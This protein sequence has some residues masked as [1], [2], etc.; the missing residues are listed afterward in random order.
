[1]SDSRFSRRNFLRTAGI[2]AV[3]AA[4][5]KMS[6]SVPASAPAPVAYKYPNPG[7]IVV[8]H[9]PLAVLGLNNVDA[10]VVQQMFDQA[11]MQ[12][13]GITSS[14]AAALASLFPGLT[15][16]KKIAIKPNNYNASVPARK[17]LAKALVTRLVQMLGGFPAANITFYERHTWTAPG[18]TAGYFGQ[19]VNFVTDTAFPNLGYTIHCDGKDRPYSKSLYEADYLINMPVAKSC[20]CGANFP[21]T[22]AFK[23]H[24]GTVNPSGTLGIHVNKTAVLDIMADAVMTTKQRIV[25]TDC[26]F[27]MYSG[28]PSGSPQSTPQTIMLAQ[29]P[30]TSD[31]QALKLINDLRIANNLSAVTVPYIAEAAAVPY[32]IGIADPALMNVIT[33]NMPV[34]LQSFSAVLDGE[35]VLLR[36]T[37]ASETN[38]SGFEIQ[39]S[40]D[41]E[42]WENVGFVRGRGT[43]RAASEYSY[44][45]VLPWTLRAAPLQYR[46]RQIDFDG[47]S[48]YS[49]VV[50]VRP[51]AERESWSMDRNYPNPVRSQTDILVHAAE[52]MH[53][54][55]E[56]VDVTGRVV[57]VLHDA[58]M[59]A[60][61]R[62]LRWDAFGCAPGVYVCRAVAEGRVKEVGM[63]VRR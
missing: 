9:H 63:V 28:G 37:T 38:N 35:N 52:R 23:N 39:R 56:V 22:L 40:R 33:V 59:E 32:E 53:L 57:A 16:S 61:T 44:A 62:R 15:T 29:D 5:P 24:M 25:L 45:D 8:V 27:A 6:G 60:G 42:A 58:H 20:A 12:F 46:L 31:Y 34:E 36:W 13:T 1:M 11:V 50:N 2:A 41:G 51:A 21:V 18:Y 14:P 48:S 54:R 26:L 43:T 4:A 55:A 49:F 19:A 17:E 3:A 10:A 30:V 47:S 7:K